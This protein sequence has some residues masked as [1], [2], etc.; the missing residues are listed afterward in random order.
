MALAPALALALAQRPS[1]DKAGLRPCTK[2]LQCPVASANE[3]NLEPAST[4]KP[5][6]CTPHI[7]IAR[8][9]GQTPTRTQHNIGG[10]PGLESPAK[11]QQKH[12]MPGGSAGAGHR[13]VGT[14]VRNMA[15]APCNGCST[16]R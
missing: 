6:P 14:G 10:P 11:Q 4:R 15:A 16:R 5:T 9:G 7:G 13:W 1:R 2:T 3:G 12:N 8:C